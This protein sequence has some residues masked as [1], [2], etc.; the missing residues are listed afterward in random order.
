[1]KQKYR[2]VT[3]KCGDFAVESWVWYWPFWSSLWWIGYSATVEDAELKI[4]KERKSKMAFTP[5]V[6]KDN[7]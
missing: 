4:L 2:I 6:V 1:M 5:K 7:L 3:T